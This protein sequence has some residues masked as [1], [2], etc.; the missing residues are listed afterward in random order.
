MIKKKCL[1]IKRDWNI[2]YRLTE[3][4]FLYLD[5]SLYSNRFS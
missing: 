2:L 1:F 5:I 4:K 3:I